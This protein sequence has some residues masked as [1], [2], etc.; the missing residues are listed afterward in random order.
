MKGLCILHNR[1][2]IDRV[3]DISVR[4]NL[5]RSKGQDGTGKE[6]RMWPTHRK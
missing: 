6:E 5:M 3:G 2:I 1:Y 4:S